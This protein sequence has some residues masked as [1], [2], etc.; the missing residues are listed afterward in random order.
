M[1]KDKRLIWA[2]KTPQQCDVCKARLE[3]EFYDV[4]TQAGPWAYLCFKCFFLHGIGLGIGRGQLYVRSGKD[5][6]KIA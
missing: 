2:G 6:I 3:D 1:D 4:C 5:F